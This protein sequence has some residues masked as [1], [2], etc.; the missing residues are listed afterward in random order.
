[1]AVR[2]TIDQLA[3]WLEKQ[4]DIV[5]IGHVSPDGDTTGSCLALYH[6]L[7]SMG[8]RVIVCLPGG[9]ANMYRD[10]P[11]GA[12]VLSCEEKLPFEAKTALAVDVSELNRMG[13]AGRKLFDSCEHRA[14]LDHHAT[15]PG[16]GE[17]FALDGAAAAV[18]ELALQ[19]IEAMNV[20]LTRE[21]ATCLFVAISTDCGQFNYSNTRQETFRAA[22]VC[23]AAG[24]EVEKITRRLYRTRTL[25]RTRLLGLVL[26]GLEI[27]EDGKMA[28]ARLTKDML[29]QANALREDNE[30]IVNYLLEIEGVVFACIAEE[31][32]ESSTKLSLRSVAPLD[33]AVNVAAPLGGGGHDRA[34]GCTLNMGMDEALKKVLDTARKALDSIK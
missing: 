10:L 27:S 7:K 12:E 23:V 31:R 2:A 13:E 16:F 11:G 33:V 18:G 17:L 4:E 19:L 29:K 8:K 32:E 1:M 15:N 3:G 34:A 30:G 9:I 6:A 26:A 14:A 22:G 20:T 25:G 21:M 28:W 24:A 5:L